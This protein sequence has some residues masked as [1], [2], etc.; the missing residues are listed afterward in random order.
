VLV[1]LLARPSSCRTVDQKF[2]SWLRPSFS[3]AT[4]RYRSKKLLVLARHCRP[5][6]DEQ[7]SE[8]LSSSAVGPRLRNSDALRF[9]SFWAVLGRES[10]LT[11]TRQL[12]DRY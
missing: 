8:L 12:G 3:L 4:P 9:P 1:G 2:S 10:D 7:P 6:R 11:C 5:V